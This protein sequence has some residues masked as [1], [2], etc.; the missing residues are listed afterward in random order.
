MFDPVLSEWINVTASISGAFPTPRYGMGF[1]SHG[2]TSK[3][4]VFGGF[5]GWNCLQPVNKCGAVLIFYSE[6]MQLY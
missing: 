5:G 3:L 2:A 6:A 1:A 4:F